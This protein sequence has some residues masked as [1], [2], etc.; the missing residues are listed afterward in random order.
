MVALDPT[1]HRSPA[2]V[3]MGAAG[4]FALELGVIGTLFKHGVNF[5]C[6]SN[7]PQAAC[8]G[9]SGTMIAIYCILGALLL[10][11]MLKPDPFRTLVQNASVRLWPLAVNLVGAAIA[12]IPLTLLEEGQGTAALVPSFICWSVGMTMMLVGLALVLAPVQRWSAFLRGNWT[13]LLPVVA[14]GAIAPS[15]AT[16]I[17]PLWHLDTITDVTFDAV[18][19]AIRLLG[20]EVEA[21]AEHKVI[22]AGDFYINVAPQCSGVEGFALV[23]LFVALYLGLFRQE[24]RFPRALLLFPIGLAASAFFNVV[25]IAVLLAIGLEGNPELA[26]G[27]FHSHA[28]WLMFT[29][30]ALGIIALA[31]AVPALQKHPVS[32]KTDPNKA[33]LA[34][35]APFFQDQTVA[36]ILPF[37]V[38]MFSALLATALTASPALFYPARVVLMTLVLALFWQIYKRLPWRMDP[39]ALG[40]GA[41]IG[42]AWVLIPVEPATGPAPYGTL[43][44]LALIG[45]FVLRGF[46]TMILVPVIEEVFFR[47]YLEQKLRLGLGR[48]WIVTAAVATA[49]L[50]AALHGRWAE[51][52]AA[53]LIF[54]WV[55]HR[56]GRVTDAIV[57]HMAANAVVFAVAVITGNLAI[58]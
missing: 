27:G 40:A 1:R 13:S 19:R 31:S 28:G 56:H 57:S 51:A 42:L 47:G 12:L 6:L 8:S 48:G 3:L 4:V 52:F 16:I 17:R 5:R 35:P 25:R 38:F 50:F 21:S 14:V 29:L 34:A 26:V 44:G 53:S 20:Y 37:A 22:G 9:A 54:S 24:L 32:D 39:V 41:L 7:W 33:K 58:I 49:I 10:L 18:T 46:G 43:T 55:A 11:G 2:P 15:F 23:T 45:W 30:V 36:F